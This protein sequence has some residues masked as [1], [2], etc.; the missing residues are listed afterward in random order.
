M[1]VTLLGA[2]ALDAPGGDPTETTAPVHCVSTPTG[3]PTCYGTFTEAIAAAT[4]GDI[5]DA[6]A[7]PGDLANDAEFAARIE[8]HDARAILAAPTTN[9]GSTVID[10]SVV[11]GIVYKDSNYHGDSWVFTESAGCD[12]NPISVDYYVNNLNASPYSD[13]GFNDSISSFLSFASCTTTLYNDWWGGGASYT[14]VNAPG[15]LYND[16]ASSIYWE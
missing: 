3:A 16:A 4:H 14:A 11:I 6:P 7:D 9:P 13:Y 1:A 8:Q 10:A 15:V 12:G 2:C 5:A